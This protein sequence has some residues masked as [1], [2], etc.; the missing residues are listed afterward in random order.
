MSDK[1][2][3]RR[4]QERETRKEKIIK[5]KPN[6]WLVVCEGEKTEPNYFKAAVDEINKNINTYP[7][8]I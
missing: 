4:Q 6:N 7:Y 1:L 8:I 5:Q 2:F 3:K